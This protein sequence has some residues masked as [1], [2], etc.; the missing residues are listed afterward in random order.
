ME[1]LYIDRLR[2]LSPRLAVLPSRA[3]LVM[4]L[5]FGFENNPIL[6]PVEGFQWLVYFC[7]ASSQD[8]KISA[9]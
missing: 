5:Y 2:T 7:F 1:L 9:L 3:K 8:E 4:F 6:D